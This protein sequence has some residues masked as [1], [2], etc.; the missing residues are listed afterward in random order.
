MEHLKHKLIEYSFKIFRRILKQWSIKDLLQDSAPCSE[1]LNDKGINYPTFSLKNEL[2]SGWYMLEIHVV[3]LSVRVNARISL[4]GSNQNKELGFPLLSNRL[5]KRLIYLTENSRLK[6]SLVAS[7]KKIELQS[8]RLV[9]V[10]RRFAQLR[11]LTK[12]QA[13]HP[14]YKNSRPRDKHAEK[15]ERALSTELVATW[16]DYCNL[17]ENSSE[18]ATYNDWVNKFD[19]LTS[20]TRDLMQIQAKCFENRPLISIVMPVYNPNLTWLKEAISSVTQQIYQNWELCIADDASTDPLV[21]PLLQSLAE[22]DNR[23]KILL[24]KQNGHIS[25][26]SN[27]ALTLAGGEWICLLDQ[28]DILAEHALYWVVNTIN[29][30]P[31]CQL[32]YSDEDKIDDTGVRSDPYFKSEWNQDLFYSHNMISHLGVYKTSLVREVGG[33]RI[34]LEGSQDYDLALRCMERIAPKEI[35]HI[36]RVLYHWRIHANSTAST[37]EAK[38]YA[39]LAGEKAINEHLARMAINAKAELIGYGYRVHYD[40]PYHAP[41]VSLIIPTRN[42]I[43]LLK[44][45]LDS[46]LIKTTYS[47]YEIILIDN[48]SDDPATVRYLKKLRSKPKIRV[49]SDTNP[50]N[51]SALNNSAINIAHGEIIGLIN[52]DV[53]VISPD[54]LTE[55]VSHAL[56]PEVGAVG[57]KLWYGDDTI[58]HAGIILGIN[59]IA[60]H[61]HRFTP[62]SDNGYCAR[63]SLIQSLSA[64]TGAC[65]I[66]RK[67]IYIALGGLNEVDLK[68][69]CNDVDFCLRLLKAGYRNI[70]TPY[71]ELYHHESSSRGFDDNPEKIERSVKEIA[72]MQ[73][74]WGDLL[75]NDPAYNP[76]LTLDSEDFSLAWPP[77]LINNTTINQSDNN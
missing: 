27:S 31:S 62:K 41:L 10:T 43:E 55:M 46:I 67:S 56:R 49:I 24:R 48:N 20:E 66:V 74:H 71:A 17:F 63:A 68:V 35:Q 7:Q 57:A 18:L 2:V 28:D 42:G 38:P 8:F 21:K 69:T 25:A 37:T 45:C 73:N 16:T 26:A 44:K 50:F 6:F 5:S 23:I 3:S 59:G 40:L 1:I 13:L 33:F 52:N 29:T 19:I 61:A 72:Y 76:N 54:W 39:M 30:C 51:F 14:K 36:P 65:L 60:G 32:I 77:R 75:Q 12:L 47:N 15:K 53:E 4:Y 11:M 70:W 9:K 22:K 64:V 34:G 58:Q